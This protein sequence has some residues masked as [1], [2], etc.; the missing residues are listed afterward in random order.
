ME[1]T[2]PR[3]PRVRLTKRPITAGLLGDAPRPKRARRL[4]NGRRELVRNAASATNAKPRRVF[5]THGGGSRAILGMP[6]DQRSAFGKAHTHYRDAYRAHVGSAL[7]VPQEDLCDMA[8]RLKLLT[9][10]CFTELM[11]GGVF[12]ADGTLR[13]A[14]GALIRS[15][16][17]LRA[18][19]SLL[20]IERR[21]RAVPTL[22]QVLEGGAQ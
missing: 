20:G 21:E 10:I 19:L 8:A 5:I 1:T 7:S 18:V 16:A 4:R 13:A 14:F 12:A 6:F 22:R 3:S 9:H 17:D 2:P 11:Q 15:E